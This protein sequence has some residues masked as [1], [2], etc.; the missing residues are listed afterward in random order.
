MLQLRIPS[1]H[2][3]TRDSREGH[4]L[5][6]RRQQIPDPD[7]N[8]NQVSARSQKVQKFR[9][10]PGSESCANGI[11]RQIHARQ[12]S[13]AQGNSKCR[14]TPGQTQKAGKKQKRKQQAT[15]NHSRSPADD[16]NTRDQ[17]EAIA[18]GRIH[19]EHHTHYK[20]QAL[21]AQKRS[22]RGDSEKL[23]FTKQLLGDL[24]N[25]SESQGDAQ[26]QR[27]GISIQIHLRAHAGDGTQR[28]QQKELRRLVKYVREKDWEPPVNSAPVKND[29]EH[30]QKCMRR[31]P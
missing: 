27:G 12:D 8:T 14:A 26:Q 11:N 17:S 3:V 31:D 18:A 20:Q 28:E 6:F 2:L 19:R 23:R 1:L 5:M 9:S 24:L 25:D 13:K 29:R 21:D 30:T 16:D 10:Y 22:L 7:Q 15:L 4:R